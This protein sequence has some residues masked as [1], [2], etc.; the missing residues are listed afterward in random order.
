MNQPILTAIISELCKGETPERSRALTNEIRRLSNY[1]I[2]VWQPVRKESDNQ[3]NYCT[4]EMRGRTFIIL[5]TEEKFA[6]TEQG[7]DFLSGS[8]NK[9]I[10]CVL[11][12]GPD[13]IAINPFTEGCHCVITREI[14]S[15]ILNGLM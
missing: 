4:V 12:G 1:D 6:K 10:D 15:A 7:V 2:W 11:N 5:F 13:G 3:Y 9:M 8:I 14:L